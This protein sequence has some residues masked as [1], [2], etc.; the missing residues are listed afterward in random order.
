MSLATGQQC[1]FQFGSAIDPLRYLPEGYTSLASLAQKTP[2]N[3]ELPPPQ[4]SK[5]KSPVPVISPTTAEE[6]DIMDLSQA[7]A[8][9]SVDSRGSSPVSPQHHGKF[10]PGTIDAGNAEPELKP[11]DSTATTSTGLKDKTVPTANA[12]GSH[13][14]HY[15]ASLLVELMDAYHKPLPSL[16]F[17]V[18]VGFACKEP[19]PAER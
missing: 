12:T 2:A 18:I 16:Y 4:V 7:L 5:A 15:P 1:K 3:I 6:P 13:T 14:R 10:N 17:E 19:I 11:I 9:M 8:Q